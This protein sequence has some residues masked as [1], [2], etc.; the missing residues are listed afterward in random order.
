MGLLILLLVVA[1]VVILL[2]FIIKWLFIIGVVL[3]ALALVSYV[4]GR[5]RRGRAV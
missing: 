4:M 1:L 5:S 2:G 3:L